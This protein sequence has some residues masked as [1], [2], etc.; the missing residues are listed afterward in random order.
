MTSIQSSVGRRLPCRPV[1][2]PELL[3][4][5][6]RRMNIMRGKQYLGLLKQAASSWSNDY[7]PSMGAALSYYTLFSI[8]PLLLIVIAVAGWVFG[9]E[10]ARGEIT[11]G[12]QGLMGDEGAKAIEEMVAS[13]S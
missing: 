11:A 9:D 5:N 4:C 3:Q 7:A 10:A 8:A 2:C 12:L 13:A 1:D 6:D